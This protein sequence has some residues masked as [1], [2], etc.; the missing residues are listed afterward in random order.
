MF[1]CILFIFLHSTNS[2]NIF[3]FSYTREVTSPSGLGC[4]E[5]HFVLVCVCELKE[6]KKEN[7]EL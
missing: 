4:S 5:F 1:L 7:V 2:E 6:E 3:S